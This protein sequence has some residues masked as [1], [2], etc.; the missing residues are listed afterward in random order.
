MLS[1]M[2]STRPR[3]FISRPTVAE[4][5]QERRPSSRVTCN[6]DQGD[7]AVHTNKFIQ[8]DGVY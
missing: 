5:R 1:A 4:K 6:R 8:S 2:I 7:Q 3:V